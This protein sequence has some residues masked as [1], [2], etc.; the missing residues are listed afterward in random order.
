MDEGQSEG[1]EGGVSGQIDRIK[2]FGG[3]ISK[4]RRITALLSELEGLLEG[5]K[6]TEATHEAER[7]QET[8]LLTAIYEV[9]V[10]VDLIISTH[11]NIG[12]R[13]E[14]I[15]DNMRDLFQAVKKI[16]TPTGGK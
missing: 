1:N 16:K 12:D 2:D 7:Q 13:L 4:F 14:M 3:G 6:G 10:K 8:R 11:E 9:M 5:K 15:E